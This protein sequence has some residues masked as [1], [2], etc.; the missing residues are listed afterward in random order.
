MARSACTCASFTKQSNLVQKLGWKVNRHTVQRTGP[1]SCSVG[2]CLAEGRGSKSWNTSTTLH[3]LSVS[4]VF[5]GQ[6]S[7]SDLS[8]SSECVSTARRRFHPSSRWWRRRGGRTSA[9]PWSL[10]GSFAS[11]CAGR[12]SPSWLSSAGGW[13]TSFQCP[14][15]PA[16]SYRDELAASQTAEHKRFYQSINRP[17]LYSAPYKIRTAVLHDVKHIRVRGTIEKQ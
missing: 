13:C 1:V 2:R 9:E 10:S 11:L 6:L 4:V 5:R 14:T 8:S 15:V 7:V 17:N 12:R 16:A 3:K